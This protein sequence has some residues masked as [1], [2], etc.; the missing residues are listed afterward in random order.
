MAAVKMK[1]KK[2]AYISEIGKLL[3]DGKQSVVDF[4]CF[5]YN[6]KN[7]VK[8]NFKT[9]KENWGNLRNVNLDLAI[10]HI[11]N[12]NIDDAIFRLKIL[13]FLIS[14][15]DEEAFALLAFCYLVKGKKT[16]SL[17]CINKTNPQS[18]HLG[19][20]SFLNNSNLMEIP[21]NIRNEY[22]KA[23]AESYVKKWSSFSTYL[24][25]ELISLLF[26]EIEE[27]P[28]S[29]KI[30]DLGSGAGLIASELDYRLEKN[31][32]ITGVDNIK[33]LT[34]YTNYNK[35]SFYDEVIE[36]STKEFLLEKH[37]KKYNIITSFCSLDFTRDLSKYFVK[38]KSL[39]SKN[40]Y[41][42][43]LLQTAQNTYWN[44]EE[45]NFVFSVQDVKNQLTLA[46]FEIL[47]IKKV[48]LH[49]NI[50][51]NIFIVK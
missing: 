10:Y 27:L 9:F 40:G 20:K 39:L 51:Y 28:A 15:H 38:I 1:N 42:A 35:R 48:K 4:I 49:R 11:N 45:N 36:Q 47:D 46:N 2:W 14:P 50:F 29:C 34:K 33:E 31:Y 21:D 5:L 23:S 19:L 3:S 13:T 12:G 18:D 7:E 43:F 8:S 41:F 22:R 6:T 37:N 16:K 25:K 32:T 24:P 44:I 17:E 26:S 30:L